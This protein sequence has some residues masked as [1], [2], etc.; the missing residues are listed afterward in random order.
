M[1]TLQPEGKTSF[2]HS[3]VVGT[4]KFP[5]LMR[6]QLEFN[7]FSA[8]KQVNTK[9]HHFLYCKIKSY[10][11]SINLQN[12]IK[13]IM[14]SNRYSTW[15]RRRTKLAYHSLRG[16][17]TSKNL[18]IDLKKVSPIRPKSGFILCD[19]NNSGATSETRDIRSSGVTFSYEFTLQNQEQI[20]ARS[21]KP[22]WFLISVRINEKRCK[23]TII[24]QMDEFPKPNRVS[25]NLVSVL[26]RHYIRIN[27]DS[28][29]RE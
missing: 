9:Y 24:H 19:N 25:K 15:V 5:A 10:Y 13:H 26:R 6:I 21:T 23:D 18:S 27:A 2:S 29:S 4:P 7:C 12:P 8:Y 16:W 17:W 14:I 20:F 1:P 3:L 11:K 22:L 28:R